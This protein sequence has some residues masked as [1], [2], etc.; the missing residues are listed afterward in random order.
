M[1]SSLLK[2]V[3]KPFFITVKIMD[4][5]ALRSY[6]VLPKTPT[7]SSKIWSNDKQNVQRSR[8]K[9]KN[10]DCDYIRHNED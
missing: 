4:Y 2:H 6:N 10:N 8:L 9:L 5:T 7:L 1:F 3:F